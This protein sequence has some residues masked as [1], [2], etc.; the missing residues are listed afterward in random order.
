MICTDLIY[1][2]RRELLAAPC[3]VKIRPGGLFP[4]EW[5]SVLNSQLELLGLHFVDALRG[6]WI[7]TEREWSSVAAR[8]HSGGMMEKA[9]S[10]PGD[11]GDGSP[12]CSE[13]RPQFF[14]VF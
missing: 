10:I 14:R 3:T 11:Q 2:V 6:G 1:S 9:Q 12:G 13:G 5:K 8:A 4:L 7:R